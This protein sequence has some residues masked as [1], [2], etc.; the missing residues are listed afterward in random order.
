MRLIKSWEEGSGIYAPALIG[1]T[2]RIF[3]QMLLT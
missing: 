2:Q 1:L 3:R